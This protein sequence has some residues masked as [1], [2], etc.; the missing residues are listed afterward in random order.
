MSKDNNALRY[1]SEKLYNIFKNSDGLYKLF[2]PKVP[3]TQK[4]NNKYRINMMIKTKISKAVID[5]IYSNLNE[6]EKKASSKVS[7]SIT[8][9]P[10]NI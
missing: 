5:K 8:R 7:Y 4:I 1:E 2:S 10:V 3:F 6:Y 9:N